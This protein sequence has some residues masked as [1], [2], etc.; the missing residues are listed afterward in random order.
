M[1]HM[2]YGASSFNGDISKWDTSSVTNMQ[3]MFKGASAFNQDISA[4]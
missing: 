1:A 2:F 4:W 3:G